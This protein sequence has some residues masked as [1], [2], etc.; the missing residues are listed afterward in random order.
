[1]SR[2]RSASYGGQ[3]GVRHLGRKSQRDGVILGAR[4]TCVQSNLIFFV[5]VLVRVHRVV[6]R[7][8][9]EYEYEDESSVICPLTSLCINTQI[10]AIEAE[11]L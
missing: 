3:A 11:F 5:L 10:I 8:K 4:G 7:T 1:M 6:S 9:D 2:L